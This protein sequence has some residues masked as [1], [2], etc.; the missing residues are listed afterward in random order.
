MEFSRQE[1]EWVAISFSRGIFPTQELNP[2]LHC[3]QIL[4]Q[5][6][7]K[8]SPVSNFQEKY[9]IK[10]NIVSTCLMISEFNYTINSLLENIYLYLCE[11][12][13]LLVK[14]AMLKL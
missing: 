2:G 3:R 11:S 4:Y 13:A 14:V 1:L 12:K 6:S 5:L 8:G 9:Y 10:E 7:F